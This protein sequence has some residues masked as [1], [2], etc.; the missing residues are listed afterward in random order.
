[1]EE[2]SWRWRRFGARGHIWM[3]GGRRKFSSPMRRRMRS[4]RYRSVWWLLLWKYKLIHVVM[5]FLMLRE[6][7]ELNPSKSV[8]LATAAGAEISFGLGLA[9]GVIDAELQQGAAD[10]LVLLEKKQE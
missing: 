8:F 9:S 4:P 3:D 6:D 5:R 10:L 1:M 7:V 2:A